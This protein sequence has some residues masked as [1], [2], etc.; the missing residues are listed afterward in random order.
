MDSKLK[1]TRSHKSG[2][3]PTGRSAYEMSTNLEFQRDAPQNIIP[4]AGTPCPNCQSAKI[5]FDS[6]LNLSC[7]ECGYLLTGCFT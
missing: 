1:G 2:I 4:K 3:I 5:E 7:P 6:L